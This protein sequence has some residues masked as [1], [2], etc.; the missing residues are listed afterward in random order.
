MTYMMTKG[1]VQDLEY[2]Y[3]TITIKKTN[4]EIN[5][6]L[7]IF[8]SLVLALRKKAKGTPKETTFYQQLVLFQTLGD[9]VKRKKAQ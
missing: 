3:K 6:I 9:N 4:H 2:Q 8:F 1:K 7:T 5:Y